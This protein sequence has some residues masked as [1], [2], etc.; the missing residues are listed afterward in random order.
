[1][2]KTLKTL[3]LI[4]LIILSAQASYALSDYGIRCDDNTSCV[5]C[6]D[7]N[8]E[9]N[10]CLSKCYNK[11]GQADTDL[12]KEG[13]RNH[14]ETCRL[15]RAK[16]CAAQCWDPDEILPDMESTKPNCDEKAF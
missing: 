9:C 6:R 3:F 7:E 1:M 14:K 10:I 16:W 2:L 13:T 8:K 15:R 4:I 12:L 11:Y 5:K